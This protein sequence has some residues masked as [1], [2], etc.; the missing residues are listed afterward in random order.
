MKKKT[1]RDN[2]KSRRGGIEKGRKYCDRKEY[3]PLNEFNKASG[4]CR[5]HWK[6]EEMKYGQKEVRKE[7]G[8]KE[9]EI[10]Q[11]RKQR[12]KK[13]K[14]RRIQGDNKGTSSTLVRYDLA[15]QKQ[16]PT[17]QYRHSLVCCVEAAVG[18]SLISHKHHSHVGAGGGKVWRE[19]G[20]TKP[21]TKVE[22]TEAASEHCGYITH[23]KEDTCLPLFTPNIQDLNNE[24]KIFE[25]TATVLC[26]NRTP[27]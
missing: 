13:W 23:V 16:E 12:K 11:E 17:V 27:G 26:L 20:T 9:G 24:E 22:E 18:H 2:V 5:S 8:R 25:A 10:R 15:L 21:E 4:K 19:G 14:E 6:K 7:G 1:Q 3:G